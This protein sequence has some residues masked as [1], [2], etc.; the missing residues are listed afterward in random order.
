ML[1]FVPPALDLRNKVHDGRAARVSHFDG[2]KVKFW[3]ASIVLLKS[4]LPLGASIYDVRSDKGGGGP[5]KADE[6]NKVS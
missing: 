6:R 5:Q 2:A 3:S 1:H 4:C